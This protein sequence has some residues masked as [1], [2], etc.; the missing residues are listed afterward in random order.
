[1]TQFAFY[2]DL[3]F[4]F[5]EYLDNQILPDCKIIFPDQTVIQ[6]HKLILSNSSDVFNNFFTAG[7]EEARTGEIRITYNPGNLLPSVIRF[8]YTS[9]IEITRDN[10]MPLLEISHF[11]GINILRE[12]INDILKK[13]ISQDDLLHFVD[14][15]YNMNLTNALLMLEPILAQN[16]KAIGI[17]NFSKKLDIET[18]CNVLKNALNSSIAND[19]DDVVQ[20]LNNFLNGAQPNPQERAVL[21]D[22]VRGRIG[23][24][25]PAWGS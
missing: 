18:F 3:I 15:C 23:N 14:V 8:M 6:C 1:M 25:K 2:S 20:I 22:L 5:S 13:N 19:N 24:V 11:Y 10:I 7:T 21:D 17:D 12:Y 4:D 9:L 16:F